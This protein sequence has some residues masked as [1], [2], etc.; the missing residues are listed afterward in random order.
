M[1]IKR[2]SLPENKTHV[3]KSRAFLDI[4]KPTFRGGMKGGSNLF[5]FLFRKAQYI[6]TGNFVDQSPILRRTKTT[7]DTS[8]YKGNRRIQCPIP[9]SDTNVQH[10]LSRP[11]D[12]VSVRQQRPRPNDTVSVRQ[13]C[14]LTILSRPNLTVLNQPSAKA[15]R[16]K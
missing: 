11:N 2:G 4:M 8:K 3:L 7:S 14:V 16:T 1:G 6:S 12:T 15:G 13:L 9:A 5:I 10:Q